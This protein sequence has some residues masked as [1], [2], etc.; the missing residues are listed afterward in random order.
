M[1]ETINLQNIKILTH[2][3]LKL[4]EKGVHFPVQ[5][6]ADE[7]GVVRQH[8]YYVCKD[9]WGES[10]KAK[11][12]AIKIEDLCGVKR[13]AFFPYLKKSTFWNRLK[14]LVSGPKNQ[15]QLYEPKN[16]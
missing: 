5:Y 1:K 12:T 2:V 16:P 9:R 8:I 11:K 6:L 4:L 15:K 14:Y 13:G 7:I 3:K 10:Y